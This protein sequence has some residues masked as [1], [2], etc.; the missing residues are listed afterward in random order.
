MRTIFAFIVLLATTA[1]TAQTTNDDA[2]RRAM[3][4]GH[5]MQ[6]ERVYLHF[7]NSAY[8]LG[9]TMWFKAY[10]SYGTN[11]RVTT[12]SKVLYVELVAP[13][14]YVVETKKYKIDENGC[15][16]G[17][18][19]LPVQLLSGYYE[20]RAY[21][22]Y[23]LNWGGD[24][25]FSRVFPIFDKVN[26][27]NWD[28]KN[29]LDRKR[30]F[31][32][33]GKW[34]SQDAPDAEL[35]FYPEGGN[36]VTGLQSTVAYELRGTDGEPTEGEITIYEDNTPLLI[37]A[38]TH[39]GKG[40]FTFTPKSGVKYKAKATVE[41][42]KGKKKEHTFTL[43]EPQKEGVVITAAEA[44]DSITFTIKSNIAKGCKLGFGIIYRGLLGFY[45]EFDPSDEEQT[46]SIGKESANEGVN[47]AIVFCGNTPLVERCFFVVHNTVQKEDHNLVK[48]DIKANNERIEDLILSPHEKITL[49][50]S[51]NGE[52]LPPTA[53]LSLSVRDAQGNTRTSWSYNLYSYLL[54]GSDIKGYIPD[55]AQYFDPQNP[56]RKEQ[57]DLVM[58]TNGWTAYDWEKLTCDSLRNLQPVEYGITLKGAFYRK[59]RDFKFL[60]GNIISIEPQQ[61]NLIRFDISYDEEDVLSY[62]FRTD[63]LGEFIIQTNDFYGKRTAVLFP[64]ATEKQNDNKRYA[65]ALDRYYSPAF[66]FPHYWELNIG[67]PFDENQKDSIKQVSPFDYLLEDIEVIDK[68][69]KLSKSRPP[70]SEMR[71]NFLDEWEYA[72]DFPALH[73][74]NLYKEIAY[75]QSIEDKKRA[76]QLLESIEEPKTYSKKEENDT[77]KELKK[78]RF[79][80]SDNMIPE[81]GITTYAKR[82]FD[83]PFLKYIGY[84]RFTGD[85]REIS[86]P[87]YFP[88]KPEQR[89]ALSAA[90]VVSSAMRRHNYNWAYWVQLMVVDGTYNSDSV[91]CPDFE[92][93]RGTGDAKK[94]MNFKEIIIRSDQKTREQFENTLNYW[95]PLAKRLDL[96]APY[97]KFYLGFLSQH[98]VLNKTEIDNFPQLEIFAHSLMNDLRIGI[99]EPKNPNYVACLI[100][101]SDKEIKKG[102][103]PELYDTNGKARYTTLQG[104]NESKKFYS[105]DYSKATSTEKKD[106]RR[107]LLWCPRLSNINNNTIEVEL[108]N[109]SSCQTLQID[110]TGRCGDIYYSNNPNIA[111]R[112]NENVAIDTTAVKEEKTI[113]RDEDFIN[114]KTDPEKEKI[115]NEQYQKGV[116]HYKNE[117]YKYSLIIWSELAKAK[118]APAQHSIAVSYLNGHG[119]KKNLNAAKKHFEEAARNGNTES[120]Y[121]LAIMLREGIGCER[122][123]SLSHVWMRRASLQ[124]EP[125]AMTEMAKHNIGI[126]TDSC[127]IIAATLLC[128]AA[129]KE[130]AEGLYEYAEFIAHNPELKNPQMP[131]PAIEYTRKAASKGLIKAQHKM[132][133]HEHN[134]KNYKEAYH[135]AKELSNAGENEGTKF[136][137]DYYYNGQGV[138]RNKK[139]AKDLYRTAAAAGNKEAQE[140]LNNL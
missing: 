5:T 50:I 127:F 124:K 23:M 31:A 82:A 84:I 3:Q 20:V 8:Y 42:N 26:G 58:L 87:P 139:L 104:Y 97:Q 15:C 134:S 37:T 1:L 38:P 34:I 36:L 66:R 79:L 44:G 116:E 67:T 126:G 75:Y 94:M 81:K 83:K 29:M 135:W 64:L 76:A 128:E 45:K 48:L 136:M 35:K 110:I 60:K 22:R 119:V 130:C 118:Y 17:D 4:V 2:A 56:N 16:N 78:R 86:H 117:R 90:D 93:L 10:I 133:H 61:K 6:Q 137:A 89:F 25:I 109:S 21:T 96:L 13:E 24:A 101:Y 63:G 57:L 138:K 33:N 108:Y 32:Q 47:K 73:D 54:L 41:N 11:D 71:L 19:E 99:S 51:A 129:Q 52:P 102:V 18:F 115:Y 100:P 88:I 132:L 105:P 103:I 70:H 114:I 46:I 121:E 7:D 40:K 131:E 59:E 14:G 111:T 80:F 106:Y 113:E 120:Q 125:R 27:D 28:F 9:E 53:N 39:F 69:K 55:A 74:Y 62:T 43:P 77:I 122:N 140:I 95:T 65:F 12:P 68:K 92:Y 91:P 107:T 49:N 85:D 72:Q 30:G 123:D 98:Y 112:I